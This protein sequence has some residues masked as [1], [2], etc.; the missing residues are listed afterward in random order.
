MWHRLAN[1]FDPLRARLALALIAAL[2]PI[3]VYDLVLA[4]QGYADARQRGWDTV[5]Q[6]AIVASSGQNALLEGTRRLLVG[7]GETEVARRA[8][9]GA[10]EP[11]CVRAMARLLAAMPEYDD[12]AVVD[13]EGRVRC[14]AVDRNLGTSIA[15]TP[16][17]REMNAAGTFTI[18]YFT[19]S[20]RGSEP[21]VAAL[22]PIAEPG[23]EP[24]GALLAA[25]RLP[26]LGSLAKAGSL[27]PEGVVY[28][29]DAKGTVMTGTDRFLAVP[30]RAHGVPDNRQSPAEAETPDPALLEAIATRRLT[31]FV[32]T[33]KDGLER[34]YASAGLQNGSLFV[35]FGLPSASAISWGHYQTIAF[36]VGPVVMLLLAVGAAMLGGEFL[37]SRGIRS[38]Q[39]AV[40]A[41]S[42][43]DF[44]V[45]ANVGRSP[46]EIRQFAD[47]FAGMADRIARREGD[48]RRSIEEKDA[49]LR[50]VH[51]RVKN[52]LQIVTSFINLQAKGAA[53]PIARRVLEETRMR[54]RA[55]ALVHRYLYEA[56]D[57]RFVD[58]GAMIQAL[59]DQMAQAQDLKR[60]AIAFDLRVEP[61]EVAGSAAVPI[62]L[63]ITEAVSNAAR[64][65]Y[66]DD[67]SG[68]LRLS[69]RR[70]PDGNALLEIADDGA[71]MPPEEARGRGVGLSLMRA[72]ARQ[73]DG[74]LTISDENG[75]LVSLRFPLRLDTAD[76]EES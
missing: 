51:H 33:G 62:A 47:A 41:Y 6:L 20:R 15:D 28:L 22:L 18:G 31:E 9:R 3:V 19:L 50:E 68:T 74:E 30:E 4:Y 37:I 66:A 17:F 39:T 53:D 12:L 54:V 73:L 32:A 67:R 5:R 42:R 11:E 75:T 49:L 2:V 8:A 46:R 36:I 55:L 65:G 13:A 23:R 10:T 70:L 45:R 16:W 1:F 58:F 27:P 72:F 25:I 14:S 64:H 7:L 26:W 52:N 35:L 24:A 44:T 38:L 40:D 69:L 34:L 60:R 43:D 63:F 21:V 57:V 48:L 56:G 59:A 29:L 76:A 61:V 71:G